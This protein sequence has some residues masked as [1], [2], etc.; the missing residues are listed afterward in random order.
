MNFQKVCY[1]EIRSTGSDH[2]DQNKCIS[3]IP[4]F[5][6]HGYTSSENKKL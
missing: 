4:C 6:G 5:M 2:L 1:V 3:D